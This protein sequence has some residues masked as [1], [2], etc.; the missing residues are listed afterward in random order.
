MY[1]MSG[2]GRYIQFLLD[3]II[4]SEINDLEFVLIDY[5]NKLSKYKNMKNIKIIINTNIKPLS[6]KEIV[7]GTVF[8]NK[9]SKQFDLIHF[10]HTN[11]PFLIPINSLIT[12]HDL[13]PIK[14][15]H[16]FN[17]LKVL[18]FSL[19]LKIN[20]KRV[21]Q[22]IAVSES[23]KK[24][25]IQIFSLKSENINV[26]YH[27][28]YMNL[29]NNASL[30]ENQYGKYF[31]YVGNRKPHK[32]LDTAVRVLDKVFDKYPEFKFL[33]VGKKF[34]KRDSIDKAILMAKNKDH[35]IELQNVTDDLLQSIYR[36]AFVLVFISLYEG[37][38]IPPL[39]AFKYGVPCIAS[40]SSSIPEVVGNGGLYV[41]P[42]NEA[43]IEQAFI[44][45]IE[46]KELYLNLR[47][48]ANERYLFF[49]NYSE[50]SRTIE[51]YKHILGINYEG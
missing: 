50:L 7:Y 28:N 26:I 13:I 25:L 22:I 38:G 40:R 1:G 3:Q 12:I 37:F 32:N 43:E 14:L 16:L 18:A 51:I 2:V 20:L 35:F 11:I 36:N 19:I 31:L 45:I 21:K 48:S 29:T 8:F 47:V 30:L 9:I 49:S 24:D 46:N 39:E 5:Q 34:E 44:K 41:D 27:G 23:T 15:P 42:I 4:S 10:T 6:A 17:K 33:I